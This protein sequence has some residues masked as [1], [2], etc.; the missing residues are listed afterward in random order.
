MTKVLLNTI[1]LQAPTQ[2]RETKESQLHI[3]DLAYSYIDTGEFHKLPWVGRINGGEVLVPIDGF[4]RLHAVEW[5]ASEEYQELPDAPSVEHL[6]L[7]QVEVRITTFATMAEAII[8][9]AGVN[10]THGMKRKNGDIGSAIKAILEVEPMMF[11]H[12]PYKLNKEAIM[13]AVKC[14]SSHYTRETAQI[15]SNLSGQRDLDIYRMLE[16]GKSSR[17]IE[18][19]TGC[20]KSTVANMAKELAQKDVPV[21]SH[22]VEFDNDEADDGEEKPAVFTHMTTVTPVEDPWADEGGS[23]EPMSQKSHSE[24]S[25]DQSASNEPM[26]EMGE[27]DKTSNDQSVQKSPVSKNGQSETSSDQGVKKE[28]M[29]DMGHLDE[30]SDD[31]TS[32]NDPM[33][34]MGLKSNITDHDLM[35]FADG[36]TSSQKRLLLEYLG[37]F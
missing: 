15:R 13:A 33:A 27:S 11:M 30:T 1:N 35:K 4:H 14:S 29:A 22:H 20:S 5:L 6:D 19:R 23:F 9:A 21:E 16:E 31:Q 28:P 26:A 25:G 34:V 18:G 2:L 3:E 37:D 32:S 17:D 12:S 10:S 7:T 8:A 36:L 24:T